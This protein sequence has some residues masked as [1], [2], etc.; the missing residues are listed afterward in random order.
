MTTEMV[1]V[2][3][4][5]VPPTLA[6]FASL[7]VGILNSKKSDKIHVLVN[8]NM[9]RVQ[10]DLAAATLRINELQT[11]VAALAHKPSAEVANEVTDGK[12]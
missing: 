8:S 10:S 5:A 1:A 12:R 6:A 2:F 7:A 9:T 11:L 4:A 3:V